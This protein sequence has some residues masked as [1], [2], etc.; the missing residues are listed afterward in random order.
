MFHESEVWLHSYNAALN[1]LLSAN[2]GN[3]YQNPK[4][5]SLIE[6]EAAIYADAAVKRFKE[7][8]PFPVFDEA[9][10]N[11]NPNGNVNN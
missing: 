9:K 1:G 6:Q 7:R 2:S 11:I 5:Q 10:S 4:P 3:D 8:F